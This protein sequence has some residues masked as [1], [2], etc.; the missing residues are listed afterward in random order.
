MRDLQKRDLQ[1]G[2]IWRNGLPDLN[3]SSALLLNFCANQSL[4]ITNIMFE[5]KD[6][7]KSMWHQDTPGRGPMINFVIVSSDLYVHMFWMNP[8]EEWC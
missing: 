8:G 3:P 2:V 1:G 7:P 6:V 4:S 5:H